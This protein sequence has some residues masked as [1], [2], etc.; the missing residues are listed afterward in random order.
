MESK[1]LESALLEQLEQ[2]AELELSGFSVRPG[3]TG[4]GVTLLQGRTFSGS[5]RVTCNTLVWTYAGA[6][7]TIRQ[8]PAVRHWMIAPTAS[9]HI[10]AAASAIDRALIRS[11][12]AGAMA[13]A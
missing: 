3:L 6:G 5:W 2:F 7:S 4:A 12:V 9:R 11:A 8:S 10:P 1:Q 13:N